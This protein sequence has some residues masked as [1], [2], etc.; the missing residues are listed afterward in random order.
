MHS[1]QCPPC[2]ILLSKSTVQW[3]MRKAKLGSNW[4]R[5]CKAGSSWARSSMGTRSSTASSTSNWSSKSGSPAST[6]AADQQP[7]CAATAMMPGI[8]SGPASSWQ[9]AACPC[10]HEHHPWAPPAMEEELIL[11]SPGYRVAANPWNLDIM[12]RARTPGPMASFLRQVSTMESPDNPSYLNNGPP[13]ADDIRDL[14]REATLENLAD[15]QRYLEKLQFESTTLRMWYNGLQDQSM[16]ESQR[17]H[18]YMMRMIGELQRTRRSQGWLPQ[19]QA[20][21]NQPQPPQ[22]QSKALLQRKL[23]SKLKVPL[24]HSSESSPVGKA[25]DV[26]QSRHG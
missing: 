9:S 26:Q 17:V 8:P 16:D 3:W 2:Y 7:M 11:P 15:L 6:P 19:W 22:L 10:I 1:V 18:L 25:A 5:A 12:E 13:P 24:S 14:R 23:Q 20:K 4:I 21:A